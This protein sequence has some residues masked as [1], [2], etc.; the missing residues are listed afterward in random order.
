MTTHVRDT[1]SMRASPRCGARTRMGSSCQAPAV[2]DKGRCRM[3]GGG[4]GAG[5]QPDNQNALKHG[6]YAALAQLTK[7]MK[8]MEELDKN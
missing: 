2:K 5:G 7:L 4:R 8:R 6:A 3:H 1:T